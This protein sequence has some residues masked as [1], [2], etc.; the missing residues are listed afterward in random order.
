MQATYNILWKYILSEH[1]LLISLC[2][3]SEFMVL[4]YIIRK[5]ISE[6][7]FPVFNNSTH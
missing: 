7:E 4:E 2:E 5:L 1:F 3:I 6:I